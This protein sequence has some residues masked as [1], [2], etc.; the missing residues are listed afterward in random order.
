VALSIPFRQPTL[1]VTPSN[2]WV[3]HQIDGTY[4]FTIS[5]LGWSP[6]SSLGITL[7]ITPFRLSWLRCFRVTQSSSSV[8]NKWP[9]PQG[10]HIPRSSPRQS[11]KT[12]PFKNAPASTPQHGINRFEQALT[13]FQMVRRRSQSLHASLRAR[14]RSSRAGHLSS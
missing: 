10:M 12:P 6:L 11:G 2:F 7:S 13:C 3:D 1:A 9:G 14:R 4:R 5:L 8:R